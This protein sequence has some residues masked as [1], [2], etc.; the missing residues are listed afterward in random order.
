MVDKNLFLYDLAVVAIMKNEAPYVKEWID[1]HLLAGV[2]HF[3]IYD[4]E[5]PDNFKEVVQ[6]YI[7]SGIVTYTFYP[8]KCRQLE[9]Y[10]DAVKRYRFFCRYM[11]FV[12]SDEFVFPKGNR[13]I[14][15]VLDEIFALNP[16][17]GGVLFNWHCFGSNGE[18]KADFSRGVLDRFTRRAANDWYRAPDPEPDGYKGWLG[19][20]HVKTITNPRKI[21]YIDSPHY[22][23][24]FTG[25]HTVD[26]YGNPVR[27]HCFK[28]PVTD[29]KIVI[30]HYH[31]KS[32]EEFLKRRSIR[33]QS[34][35]FDLFDRNEV[36]DDGI[37][38]YRDARKSGGVWRL[39][40]LQSRLI[41]RAFSTRW[42]K[43]Y[44][45]RCQ[46]KCRKNFTT[47]KLKIS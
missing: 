30:N 45:R 27:P 24:Y 43:I 35:I 13:S 1:Y 38:K 28:S 40:Y 17:S 39:L 26:E 8:G 22:A 6:P 18:E 42:H 11:A 44:F 5:S 34:Q 41:P 3:Y 23:M 46:T 4:N 10:I 25:I 33:G 7:D 14:V 12:D 32:R 29:N 20:I 15:E 31:T 2:D 47:A 37:I 21:D 36:F 9:C 16:T 19:N